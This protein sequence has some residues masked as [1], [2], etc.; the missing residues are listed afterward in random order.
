MDE[1]TLIGV[2]RD[3]V[4]SVKKVTSV[5]FVDTLPKSGVGKILRR[6]VRKTYWQ[7]SERCAL[8]NRGGVG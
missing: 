5:E 8:M 7:D 2:T 6:E 4:G 3:V 1:E